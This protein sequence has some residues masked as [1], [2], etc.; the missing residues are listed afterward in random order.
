VCAISLLPLPRPNTFVSL[1]LVRPAR[2]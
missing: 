2:L 1:A